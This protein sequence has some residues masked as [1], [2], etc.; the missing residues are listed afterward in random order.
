M[1]DSKL[2]NNHEQNQQQSPRQSYLKSEV[3]FPSNLAPWTTPECAEL[4][5]SWS[6]SV[7]TS[8]MLAQG[9]GTVIRSPD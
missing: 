8:H 4:R 1:Y 7:P 3:F 2:K 6:M 5:N 9:D